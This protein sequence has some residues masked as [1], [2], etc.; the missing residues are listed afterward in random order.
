MAARTEREL[1][2]YTPQQLFDLVVDVERY[3]E[4][5]PW[6]IEARVR[7]RTDSMMLVDMMIGAGPLRKQFSTAAVLHR[8]HRI[9][10]SSDDPLFDRFEQRW[11]FEPATHGVTNVE[12]YVDFKFRPRVLQ[13]LMQKTFAG[14]AIATISAYERQAHRLYGGH[15]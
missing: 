2:A 14:R 5:L 8:P 13:I 9:D 7:H 6:V 3:P 4:F 15:S 11:T 12:Y 1:L 10:I